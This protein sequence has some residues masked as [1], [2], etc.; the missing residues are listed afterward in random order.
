MGGDRRKGGERERGGVGECSMESQS[1]G[2]PEPCD[3]L[4]GPGDAVNPTE[5]STQEPK[6]GG[7]GRFNH[8]D[9]V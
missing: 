5:V 9:L 2:L 4:L 6:F 3:T 1:E 8:V 7:C